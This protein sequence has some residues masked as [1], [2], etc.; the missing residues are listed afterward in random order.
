M[1]SNRKDY[2]A[3]LRQGDNLTLSQQISMIFRLSFPAI[4]AQLST[5]IMEYIDASMVGHLNSDASAS[6]GLVSSTTWLIGGL[7]M[8]ANV[9][10]NV[11]IAH[12]IGA[13][14]DEKARRIVKQG[15]IVVTIFSLIL[16]AV[17][18]SLSGV[19]PK[20]L[21]GEERLL[22][23]ASAYLLIFALFIPVK[24]INGAATGM[25]QCSGNMKLPSMVHIAMCAMD[26]I[27]NMFFIFGTHDVSLWGLHFTMPGLGLGVMG[28]ALGTAMS[29]VVGTLFLLCFMLFR[30]D[31]LRLRKGERFYFSKEI[32]GKSVKIALPVAV[33]QTITC[34]AYIMMTRIV[35]PL[36]AVAIA[37]NSFSITAESLC[38]MP[39]YGIGSAATTLIGQSIGAGRKELTKKLGGL[40]III[41][42]G[43][44]TISGGIMYAVAPWMLGLLTPDAAIRALGTKILR[45]E[46]FA[47]PLYGASIVANG[48]FR[49]AQDTLVPS[50]MSFISMWVV[51]IPAAYFLS[52]SYGLEGVWIAMCGELMFRGVIF[53]IRFF[54]GRWAKHNK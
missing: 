32:L 30:S 8:A 54:S 37:A 26:V 29:D 38:Y 49:G 43:M 15:L 42:V 46:A 36:G 11:Q 18:A 7:C 40:L 33:E 16:M 2:L 10:F 31:K 17:S 9:G 35:A 27:F 41:G 24:Q 1:A 44:M 34:S 4:L 6:I 3:R 14:E 12:S 20:F 47:E 51:R 22:K 52:Q 39:G 25:L 45:I 19:I 53:L 13:G 28:A 5:I 48:T 21:K 23:N 50:C